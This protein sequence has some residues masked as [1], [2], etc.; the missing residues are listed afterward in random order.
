MISSNFLWIKV[1]NHVTKVYTSNSFLYPYLEHQ[2]YQPEEEDGVRSDSSPIR[3]GRGSAGVQECRGES[4][5]GHHGCESLHLPASLIDSNKGT[6]S[7][8]GHC[9]VTAVT[10]PFCGLEGLQDQMSG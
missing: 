3:S 5:E 8:P 4:Q 6:G 1:L 10:L 9:A 2:P 7:R